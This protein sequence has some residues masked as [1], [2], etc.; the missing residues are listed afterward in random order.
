MRMM[1]FSPLMVAA[2][3]ALLEASGDQTAKAE[4]LA[5]D[6]LISRGQG[7]ARAAKRKRGLWEG[8]R[9][10][11]L[12]A[13]DGRAGKATGRAAALAC[14]LVAMTAVTCAVGQAPIATSRKNAE[15]AARPISAGSDPAAASLDSYLS[16]VR[17]DNNA[18][19]ATSGAIW[20][21]SGRLTR[22]STDVRAM[23]PHDLISVVVSESLAAS[24]D[25]TVKSSR[26][27]NASSAITGL[28]G[29]LHAGNALQNLVNQNS[30]AGLSAQ[31]TSA[32][33]SSLTTTFG[34]QVLDVLPNGMLVIEAARQVEFS[35][36]T[37]TI[38]L[39]GLVRPEDIS[40]QNQ[41]LSTAISS[42]ELQV[43]GKG[44]VNDYTRRPNALVRL[45]QKALIF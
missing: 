23:R 27:S 28:I 6:V 8:S 31:G 11:T 21:D 5:M 24:T 25:G 40:Q 4:T 9:R 32:T 2:C 38:V 30:A 33:N 34:G 36:Q 17:N 29:P 37:Q 15:P 39:R 43:R 14:G 26:A 35:Q 13:G 45:L 3:D 41:I 20:T 18:I 42:M 22:M 12:L 7:A 19:Q 44:I 16:R 10:M 1:T